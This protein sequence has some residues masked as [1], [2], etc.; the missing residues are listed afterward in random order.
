MVLFSQSPGAHLAQRM[1]E[2]FKLRSSR[3]FVYIAPHSLLLQALELPE[4][5]ELA[6]S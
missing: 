1:V 2:E 3:L 6:A 4:T 5:V